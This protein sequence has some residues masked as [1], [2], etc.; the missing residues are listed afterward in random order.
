MDVDLGQP[1]EEFVENL[2]KSGR[3]RTRDEV[4]RYAVALFEDRESQLALLDAEIQE[5]LDALDRGEKFTPDEVRARLAER[6]RLRDEA[7]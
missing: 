7:A 5:G 1:L 2:V 6:R 4:V 3:F